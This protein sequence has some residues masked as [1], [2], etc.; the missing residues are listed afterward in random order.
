MPI[1][2]VTQA[3]LTDCGLACV[4]M[5]T[6]KSLDAV[7]RVAIKECD[8]AICIYRVTRQLATSRCVSPAARH[9][10]ANARYALWSG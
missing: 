10:R 6:G 9:W 8:Y 3:N 7:L 4:A 5:V 1:K 2:L